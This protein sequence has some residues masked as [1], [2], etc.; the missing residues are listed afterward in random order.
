M[1]DVTIR[2]ATAHDVAAIT[3]IY[4]HAVLHGTASFE[5]EPPDET[6]MASRQRTLLAG[7]FPYLVAEGNEV[8]GYSYAGPYHTRPAYRWT[9]EGS[10]YV[11]T[12]AHRRGIG[13]ALLTRLIEEAE[14]RAFRQMVAII[15]DSQHVASIELHRALGFRPVGTL[16]TVGFKHGRWLDI[17]IMQRPLGPGDTTAP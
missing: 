11:A 17:V 16:A 12:P 3:R 1:P 9:V 5:I 6:E 13:R 15:G 14:R 7:G 2:P 10:V 4:R 8:I